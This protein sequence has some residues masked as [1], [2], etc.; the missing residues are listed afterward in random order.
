MRPG[1]APVLLAVL[2]L[3]AC[4][5]D[6]PRPAPAD[7][8][9]APA[10]AP[11]ASVPARPGASLPPAD[12]PFRYDGLWAAEVKACADPPWRFEPRRLATQGEVSCD[13]DQVART[14]AGY[15]IAATCT[16]EGP[17]Q[18]YSLTLT[19]AESAKAMLVEGGPFGR[20]IG[21]VWCGPRP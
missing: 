18:P 15:E 6:E 3:A 2:G 12:A 8:P 4:G 1:F 7:R 5:R 10:P 16:A 9:A 14:A 17:P 19:F 13:F 20:P 11:A 21:L